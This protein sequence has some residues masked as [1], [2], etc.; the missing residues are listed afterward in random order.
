MARNYDSW[1]RFARDNR[2]LD[3]DEENYTGPVL[4]YAH[5]KTDAC[6]Q[7]VWL[8][9]DS[10][11]KWDVDVEFGLSGTGLPL[12][13]SF[14]FGEEDRIEISKSLERDFYPKENDP[15]PR[16]ELTVFI[17]YYRLERGIFGIKKIV[18]RAGSHQLP[19]GDFDADYAPLVESSGSHADVSSIEPI[20]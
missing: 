4:V 3:V 6:H 17:K 8:S 14:G 12:A 11:E 2:Q 1:Y 16:E 10:S 13:L 18:A 15:R 19:E 5:M 20:L 7:A 9:G